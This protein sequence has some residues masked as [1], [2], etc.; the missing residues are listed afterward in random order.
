ME[1]E[2][3]PAKDEANLAKHGRSL[4]DGEIVFR[5]ADHLIVSAA[6][7]QDGEARFKAIGLIGDRLHT[8]VFVRRGTAIRF[9]SVRKSNATE[10]RAYPG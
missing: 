5:D 6:R 2:F 1:I 9:I 8:A 10:A 4:A 7:P 3:D